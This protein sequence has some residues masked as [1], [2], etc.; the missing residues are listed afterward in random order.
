MSRVK[1]AIMIAFK[2]LFIVLCFAVAAVYTAFKGM[3]TG[4]LDNMKREL[5]PEDCKI[6]VLDAGFDQTGTSLEYDVIDGKL[7]FAGDR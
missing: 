4:A 3:D 5:G 1:H 2:L 7:I 6:L